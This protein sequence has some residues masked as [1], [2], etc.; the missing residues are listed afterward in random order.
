MW[1]VLGKNAPADFKEFFQQFILS[2]SLPILLPSKDGGE[3]VDFSK[4]GNPRLSVS[5]RTAALKKFHEYRA[6]ELEALGKL[7]PEKL[8][9]T[10]MTM[11]KDSLRTF[12]SQLEGTTTTTQSVFTVYNAVSPHACK[13]LPEVTCLMP[14]AMCSYALLFLLLQLQLCDGY[15]GAAAVSVEQ[16]K[17]VDAGFEFILAGTPFPS[18]DLRVFQEIHRTDSRVRILIKNQPTVPKIFS[19]LMAGI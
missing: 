15:G 7:L 17:I 4:A 18:Q 19:F 2:D 13:I 10:V 12:N 8:G 9:V 3:L 1:K 16:Y 11:G 14:Y 6:A 5:E